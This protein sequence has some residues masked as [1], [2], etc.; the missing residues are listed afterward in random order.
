[1]KF[2]NTIEHVLVKIMPV[3]LDRL[4]EFLQFRSGA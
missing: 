4:L 1:M 3:S 2:S